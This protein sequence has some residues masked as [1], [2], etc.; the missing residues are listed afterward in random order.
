LLQQLQDPLDLGPA[1][2]I[3][4][5]WIIRNFVHEI[6]GPALVENLST[7]PPRRKDWLTKFKLKTP[8]IILLFISA[9]L[10]FLIKDTQ[11]LKKKPLKKDTYVKCCTATTRLGSF[12]QWR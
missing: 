2:L 7:K 4:K 8:K 12:H 9:S 11:T 1:V 3:P 5:Q 10:P 6:V